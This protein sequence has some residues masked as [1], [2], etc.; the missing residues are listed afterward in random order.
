[1][2]IIRLIVVSM[3][4]E[5]YTAMVPTEFW[6]SLPSLLLVGLVWYQWYCCWMRKAQRFTAA[7]SEF[8]SIFEMWLMMWLDLMLDVFSTLWLEML[9]TLLLVLRLIIQLCQRK[10]NN[11]AGR[12]YVAGCGF[13]VFCKAY[14]FWC[15]RIL[16]YLVLVVGILYILRSQCIS[17]KNKYA[18]R[19]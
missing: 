1:M 8:E 4:I 15:C 12:C 17:R 13:A 10:D 2:T 19:I 18:G 16:S 9:L 11:D 6:Q 14:V 5:D 7:V 3:T